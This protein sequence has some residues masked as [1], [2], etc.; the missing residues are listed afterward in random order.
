MKILNL[1]AIS[2]ALIIG[3]IVILPSCNKEKS[4]FSR[5]YDFDD[6]DEDNDDNDDTDEDTRI[7]LKL[8][9]KLSSYKD[10]LSRSYYNE[11]KKEIEEEIIEIIE[12]IKS[13]IIIVQEKPQY[14]ISQVYIEGG[15]TINE[16]IKVITSNNPPLLNYHD[17]IPYLVILN[18][19]SYKV[20]NFYVNQNLEFVMNVKIEPESSNIALA[21]DVEIK[22]Y[23]TTEVLLD[24]YKLI[25]TDENPIVSSTFNLTKDGKITSVKSSNEIPSL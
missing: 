7:D 9:F 5:Y 18:N 8:V 4:P 20:K 12:K 1:L 2:I 23:S 17:S 10:T 14:N 19:K 11:E 25:S 22:I 13:F 24:S 21:G 15:G 6:E 16:N 3:T